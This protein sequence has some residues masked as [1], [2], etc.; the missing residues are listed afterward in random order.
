[1]KHAVYAELDKD[2]TRTPTAELPQH[3]GA[4]MPI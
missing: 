3:L 2:L 4:V 1:V